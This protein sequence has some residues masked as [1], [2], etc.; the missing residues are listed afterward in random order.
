[1]EQHR[2][3]PASWAIAALR[4]IIHPDFREEIEGDI[5]ETYR[6]DIMS[7]GYKTAQLNFSKNFFSL[8]RPRVVFNFNH[9][10]MRRKQW[11]V[12]F[13]IFFAIIIAA[14]LPFLPGPR[15]QVS[16]SFSQFVQIIG[17]IG[18]VFVPFGLFWLMVEIRNRKGAKLNRWSSGYYPA[19]LVLT[20]IIIFIPVQIFRALKSG[21]FT[22]DFWPFIVIFLIFGFVFFRIRKL[23]Y[24]TEQRFN[25]VPLFIVFLPLVSILCSETVVPKAAALTRDQVINKTA[26]LITALENYKIEHTVYPDRL[27][28][29]VGKYISSIP[30]FRKM[31]LQAYRYEKSGE[32][33]QLSFEQ[34]YHWYATEVVAYQKYG[35]KISKANYENYPTTSPDWRVYFAD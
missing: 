25:A 9:F 28:D 21:P 32:T 19:L 12:F 11:I 27:E 34:Y 24:K 3:Q 13:I 16:H 10:A 14:L 22:F 1:M 7:Y 29:L 23:K 20:P 33:F 30:K 5:L 8:C 26:P 15:N 31:G 6:N 18:L 4:F 2:L 17:Y 35:H